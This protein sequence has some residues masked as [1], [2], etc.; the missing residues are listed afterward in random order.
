MDNRELEDAIFRIREA[1][2]FTMAVLASALH[3]RGSLSYGQLAERL[4]VVLDRIP[5]DEDRDPTR[6]MLRELLDLIADR[7]SPPGGG[8]RLR[9]VE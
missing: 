8:P 6:A 1:T 7:P 3:H 2:I 9:L 5:A 4:R